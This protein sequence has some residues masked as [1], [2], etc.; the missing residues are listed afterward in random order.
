[1]EIYVN[2]GAE[3]RFWLTAGLLIYTDGTRSFSTL[4]EVRKEREGAPYLAEGQPLTTAFLRVLA[5]G[6]GSRMQPEI[7]PGEVLVRTP[8][9]LVW[10]SPAK[11][12]T[13]LFSP[14]GDPDRVLNGKRFPHPALVFKVAGRELYIR[15]LSANERPT[16]TTLLKTAPYWN[17]GQ[18]GRV[19]QGSMRAP[20]ESS[21][22]TMDGWERAFFQSEFTHVLGAVRLT[23]YP[24][25]FKGLWKGLAG[26]R[27][28][29]PVELL[30]DPRQSLAE[31]VSE[32]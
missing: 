30:T 13:M 10:W 24:A 19:C 17:V 22:A 7:L 29:F 15:A 21:V 6:L 31:F 28:R 11:Q 25:G 16:A 9:L 14:Q 27:R 5:E 18:D 3:Q 8:D 12:R 26:R 4:H 20:E 23:K 32:G 1:M 2:L